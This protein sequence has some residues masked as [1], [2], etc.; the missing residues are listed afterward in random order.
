M[1]NDKME[2]IR[3][4]CI[5]GRIGGEVLKKIGFILIVFLLTACSS[6]LDVK[7]EGRPLTI[8]VIGTIP[9]I[10]N[11][12][13]EW[14][15][16]SLETMVTNDTNVDGW[17]VTEEWFEEASEPTYA[18]QFQQL[19]KPI[20]FIGIAPYHYSIFLEEQ[21]TLENGYKNEHLPYIQGFV[22]LPDGTR[23]DMGVRL[24]EYMSEQNALEEMYE[25]VIT[26]ISQNS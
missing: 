8:G 22:W 3:R 5:R 15:T 18:S 21:T 24:N 11:D 10:E 14:K 1:I 25:G 9:P 7:Y 2:E 20:F 16:Y 4:N 12:L 19:T 17:I 13:I 23:K 26:L 6:A